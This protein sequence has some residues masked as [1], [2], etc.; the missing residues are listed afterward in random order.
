MAYGFVK[1][2]GGYIRVYSEVS[3]GTTVK[4]YLP[5]LA[6]ASEAASVPAA[7]DPEFEA[8]VRAKAAETVLVVEDGEGVLDFAVSV[9]EDLGYRVLSA[10]D[11]P[12]ALTILESGPTVDLLFTDAVLPNGITGR[13]LADA[14]LAAR[15]KLPILFT[16]GYSRNAIVHQRRL[17][18][19]EH[20]L[21]KPY[22]QRELGQKIRAL[23]DRREL[24]IGI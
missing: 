13:Q 23:L 2:S 9:L 19:N 1:Q 18:G 24:A 17:D 12:E 6:Q 14:A 3:Q 10:K 7:A 8:V 11:G 21:S 4:I 20:L 16:T 15:P 22:M 5:R